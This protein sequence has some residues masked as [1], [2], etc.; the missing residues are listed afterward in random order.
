MHLPIATAADCTERWWT[1]RLEGNMQPGIW[2]HGPAHAIRY[3]VGFEALC[4]TNI[5]DQELSYT[6]SR[7]LDATTNAHRDRREPSVLETCFAKKCWLI[8]NFGGGAALV[9]CCR[10]TSE[11][12]HGTTRT[13]DR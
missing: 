7:E 9:R 11:G 2:G 5:R 1:R 6:Y 8:G 12:H 10:P 13:T 3:R 4:F